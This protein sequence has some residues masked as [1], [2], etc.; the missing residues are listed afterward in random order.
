MTDV[1]AD[2]CLEFVS[3]LCAA[4]GVPAGTYRLL[5]ESEWEYACRAGTP[6]RFPTGDYDPSFESAPALDPYGWYLMNCGTGP[7]PVGTRRAN[8]WGLSDMY[9]NVREW[10]IS[11]PFGDPVGVDVSYVLRGGGWRSPAAD[12][13]AFVREVPSRSF[14]SDDTGFRVCRPLAAEMAEP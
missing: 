2:D 8:A 12:C 13:G 4:E 1:T 11:G 7:Q 14:S 9:G 6:G 10:C 3:R 5:S